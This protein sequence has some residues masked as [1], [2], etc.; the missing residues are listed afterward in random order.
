LTGLYNR[1]YFTDTATEEL[2]YCNKSEHPFSILM[3]DI[4]HFKN[5]NDTYGHA[6]GDAV[7][8][9]F[10]SRMKETV[11]H[12]TITARY[13]GEEFIAALPSTNLANAAKT[14]ERILESINKNP[15]KITDDLSIPITVSIGVAANKNSTQTLS[16]IIENADT[17]LYT[18]KS[19]GRN[20]VV[21]G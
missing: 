15:F 4:D 16:S 9:I 14:A 6:V 2:A 20:R 1:R 17:A 12:G 7:L 10:A 18:A 3:L 21:L 5:V 13:G 19:E 11:R 8:K